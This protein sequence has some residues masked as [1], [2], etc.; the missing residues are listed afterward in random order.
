MFNLNDY[1][2]SSMK[3]LKVSWYIIV[4]SFVDPRPQ[5][6]FCNST[7]EL[8]ESIIKH[9]DVWCHS[10][11]YQVFA[12]YSFRNC[13]DGQPV[14]PKLVTIHNSLLIPRARAQEIA[15]W[16]NVVYFQLSILTTA[17]DDGKDA[18]GIT[19]N[20][21]SHGSVADVIPTPSKEFL[22]DT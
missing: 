1:T 4:Y 5:D 6:F 18:T 2:T 11:L 14:F 12:W 16:T 3:H 8:V 21:F 7:K 15:S 13:S 9:P 10:R 22:V 17:H 19:T 20:S